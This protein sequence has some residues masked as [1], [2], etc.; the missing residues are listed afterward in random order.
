MWLR[1]ELVAEA[2]RNAGPRHVLHSV[3]LAML[4]GAVALVH[5]G[6]LS[7]AIGQQQALVA[8][9][10]NVWIVRHDDGVLLSTPVCEAL[11]HNQGVE[12]AG[13]MLR[14]QTPDLALAATAQP[15]VSVRVTPGALRAWGGGLPGLGSILIG[16]HYAETGAAGV[17]SSVTSLVS[18]RAH[19]IDGLVPLPAP[20]A[21]RS[22]IV[23][24]HAPTFGAQECWVRMRPDTL[25]S[26][27][28]LLY[29]AFAHEGVAVERAL[30]PAAQ[31]LSPQDQW[32]GFRDLRLWLAAGVASG[33]A[34]GFLWWTRRGEVAVY[35]TFGT[36]LHEIRAIL[37][38]ET[39]LSHVTGWALGTSVALLAVVLA[40]PDP[41]SVA[42]IV[43]RSSL[44]T[45][46]TSLSVAWALI[47]PLG[48][49]D[50]L[51]AL[52]RR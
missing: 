47:A 13:G 37:A 17:G 18:G 36:G 40:L 26:G 33:L 27:P 1:S 28:D 31:L 8:A 15:L 35:R 24:I 50:L 30:P 29:H 52:K 7:N 12:A 42:Q 45:A 4:V 32:H 44:S 48:R 14:A 51:D 41:A 23:I 3:L 22:S 5:A 21:L 43:L 49:G 25:A 34:A 10:A 11:V 39:C 16:D 19:H 20:E 6:V 38:L 46:L 2:T 9:G